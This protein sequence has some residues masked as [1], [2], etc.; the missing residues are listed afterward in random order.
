MAGKV[1]GSAKHQMSAD[2]T[3][4]KDALRRAKLLRGE[5]EQ[6]RG[7]G[8]Q[9]REEQGDP[10]LQKRIDQILRRAEELESNRKGAESFLKKSQTKYFKELQTLCDLED[11]WETSKGTPGEKNQKKI[12]KDALRKFL[13]KW[14]PIWTAIEDIDQALKELVDLRDELRKIKN[15]SG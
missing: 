6:L 4:I 2:R 3:A 8:L 10:K 9:K 1:G 14:Q 13:S 7:I 11:A 5:A 12:Y 15:K